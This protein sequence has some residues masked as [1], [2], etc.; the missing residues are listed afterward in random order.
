MSPSRKREAVSHLEETFEVS[1]RRAC[2]LADQPRS[3]QR[4][5]PRPAS[6]EASVVSRMH[7]LV[8]AHPRFGYRRI[9]VL[10]RREGFAA[11]FKR[12]YRLWRREGL[13]VPRKRRKK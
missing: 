8:R 6:D 11:N 13:K 9:G 12:V 7:E 1:E 3:T 4:Y 5:L 2:E 10:L